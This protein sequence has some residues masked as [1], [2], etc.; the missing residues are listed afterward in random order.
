M[1]R[2]L[3]QSLVARPSFPEIDET[4]EQIGKKGKTTK[5]STFYDI[6]IETQKVIPNEIVY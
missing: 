4:I 1:R 2:F 3:R 5:L 6:E